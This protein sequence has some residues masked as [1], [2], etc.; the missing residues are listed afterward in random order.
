MTLSSTLSTLL[1]ID[2]YFNCDKRT[3]THTLMRAFAFAFKTTTSYRNRMMI[4]FDAS[5]RNFSTIYLLM[6]H[7]VTSSI[8]VSYRIVSTRRN[9]GD[10]F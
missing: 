5:S 7:M 8:I 3:H 9:H 1:L 10:C 4:R 2:I 6:M